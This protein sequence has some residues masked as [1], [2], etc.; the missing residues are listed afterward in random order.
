MAATAAV[1]V[2]A[3]AAAPRAP[4]L[5]SCVADGGPGRCEALP[6]GSLIGASAVTASRDGKSVYVAAYGADAVLAFDRGSDGTLEPN[7]CVADDGAGGCV[8]PPSDALGGASGV[9]AVPA[10]AATST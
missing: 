9:A 2:T 7:G 10:V 4:E 5:E 1:V 3:A 8:D 6:A